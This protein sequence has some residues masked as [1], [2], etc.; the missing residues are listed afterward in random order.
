MNAEPAVTLS[1]TKRAGANIIDVSDAIKATVATQSEAWPDGI[2]YRILADQSINIRNMITELQNNIFTAL[3]LVV[4]VLLFFMGTRNSL[5]VALAIPL[6]MLISFGILQALGFTLNMV[7]LFSLILALGMLVD[8]AIVVV[9]NIYRHLELGYSRIDAAIKGTREVAVAIA[10]STATTVAAFFPMV[11]WGGIMGEFMGYLP[12]TVIIVLISSLFVAICILPVATSRLM[13]TVDTDQTGQASESNT[14]RE[15]SL[16]WRIMNGYK[17]LL[18]ASIRY[19]YVSAGMGV[20]A[21]IGTF[22]I[23]GSLNH[24]TELFPSV[25][26]NRAVIN[27]RAPVGT[28]LDW[29]DQVTRRIETHLAKHPNVDVWTAESGVSGDAFIGSSNSANEARITVDFLPHATMAQPEETPRVESTFDTIQ[30]LREQVSDIP[31]VEITVEKEE[32]G[33]PVGADIEVI[34]IGPEFHAVGK[35]IQRFKRD[36]ANIEGVTEIADDYRVNRPELALR[37]DRGAAKRIGVSSGVIGNTIRT[38][39][40]GTKATTVR[41]RDRET[42]V[43]VQ[44]APEFRDDVQSILSLRL[45]GREDTSPDTFPVP[46]SAVASYEMAGGTGSIRHI[47][48]DLAV[49]ITADVPD[50][51][52]INAVQQAVANRLELYKTGEVH[53]DEQAT[54]DASEIAE[55]T[56]PNGFHVKMTGSTDEQKETEAFLSW[57]FLIAIALITI[58]LV[59][60]FDSIAIP[61]IILGTVVL[62][63]IGVLWG[64]IITGTPF[65]IMMTGIGIISLAG[66]VVNNAI[67]LLDYVKQLRNRGS[68]S[69]RHWCKP[70]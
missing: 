2:E 38:A 1:V 55:L 21:L 53:A 39:I 36:L 41:E 59:T 7:V 67:V 48:Q 3:L 58:I 50:G 32:M 26:P 20:A 28:E 60:Q 46:I 42:D 5:F 43:V 47:D 68:R 6:S 4:G 54:Y 35:Y 10:A 37:T 23:Y 24:G 62:S 70:E 57:A 9:E 34:V 49:S 27:L 52:N 61:G 15:G 25:E 16:R 19:R 13:R 56:L 30:T 14:A 31:G 45:P 18:T 44:L 29:T 33:P 69:K 12:K 8:N 63:L 64:L 17:T 66:V 11:F 51:Y 22:I 40:A 65:G